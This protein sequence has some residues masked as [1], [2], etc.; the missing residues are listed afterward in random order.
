MTGLLP[1]PRLV[2]GPSALESVQDELLLMGVCRPVLM[3]S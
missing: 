1:L 3:S 2:F